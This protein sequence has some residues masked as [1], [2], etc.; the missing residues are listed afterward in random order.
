MLA[1]DRTKIQNFLNLPHYVPKN[2]Y[3][4]GNL[5]LAPTKTLDTAQLPAHISLSY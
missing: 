2:N 4:L 1:Y 3:K 5:P